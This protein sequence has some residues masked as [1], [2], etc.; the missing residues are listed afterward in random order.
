MSA[1]KA[2]TRRHFMERTAKG[3]AGVGVASTLGMP[4]VLASRT[5]SETIGIGMVGLG[6]RG[7]SLLADVNQLAGTEVRGICDLYTGHVKRAL[8][9]IKNPKV[10]VHPTYHDLLA[11]PAIDAV[12]VATPDFWHGKIATDAAEA[13]KDVYVEKPATQTV[14]QFQRL[15]RAV[16]ENRR[17]FQLGHQ[18]R[19]T[20]LYQKAR[21]I[22]NTGL[23]GNVHVCRTYFYR[24]DQVPAFRI[25]STYTTT[26]L[27]VDG[28]RE[29]VNWDAYLEN[30]TPRPWDP[31]RF[32]HW[33]CYWEYGT[34][35]M[36]NIMSHSTDAMNFLLEVGAP[37]TCVTSG[38][39]YVYKDGRDTPET[40]HSVF[41]YPDRNLSV[42][43]ANMRTNSRDSEGLDILGDQGM[44]VINNFGM[45]VYA[46]TDNKLYRYFVGGQPQG[47]RIV[48]RAIQDKP[49]FEMATPRENADLIHLEDFANAVRTRGTCRCNLDDA[50]AEVVMV[51]LA[52]QSYRTQHMARWEPGRG[53]IV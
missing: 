5:P 31:E 11:D 40:F 2:V 25:H 13:G 15:D 34:G 12:I 47:T 44:L 6:I 8:K 1:Q 38:G 3:A 14:E 42:A 28:T 32:F 4:A 23:L 24:H 26:G 9:D 39:I 48:D 17:V 16:R 19:S 37:A 46:E 45:K 27:P 30:A 50:L 10:K 41:E 18:R 7:Y 29:N 36:G 35:D 20:A 33:H 51:D 53:C 21:E 43:Y 52:V 49:C 22:V